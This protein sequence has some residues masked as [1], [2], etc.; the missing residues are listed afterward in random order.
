MA[1]ALRGQTELAV[2]FGVT[3]VDHNARMRQKPFSQR[4]VQGSRSVGAGQPPAG[5][6]GLRSGPALAAGLLWLA[7]GLSA[8]YWFLQARG[9][10]PWMPVQGLAPSAPQ[11]DVDSVA[12]A[13]GAM[14]VAEQPDAAPA[15]ASRLQLLGVVTQGRQQGAALIAV[16]GQ[17][18]RPWRV[19]AVVEE[20][21]VLQSV[22]RRTVQLGETRSGPTTMTLEMPPQPADD[23]ED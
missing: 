16:D 10:G 3:A 22:G 11:A 1:W 6:V 18:P 13:L 4:L 20:G 17:P 7:A 19:G 23:A 9:H 14:T 15:P 2:H 5:T 12:E 8:G 21:L